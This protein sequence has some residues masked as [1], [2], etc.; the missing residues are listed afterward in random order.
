[1]TEQ[2]TQ[3]P[4]SDNPQQNT[5]PGKLVGVRGVAA[6]RGLGWF[7]EGFN[8]FKQAPWIWILNGLLFFIILGLL[9]W[10]PKVPVFTI[11]L[12]PAFVG[13]LML[14][15]RDL[16]LGQRLRVAHLFAGFQNRAGALIGLG[17]LNLIL[18]ILIVGVVFGVMFVL[19]SVDLEI[20]EAWESG[21]MNEQQMLFILLVMLFMLPLFM[22]FWFAPTLIVLHDDV[23]ILE[24]MRLSFLGCLK[25]MLPFL[26]YG[27]VGFILMLLANILLGLGLLVASFLFNAIHVYGNVMLIPGI[28]AFILF[29]L[30]W[31]VFVSVLFGSI[32]ASYK[33]IFLD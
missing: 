20:L 2:D 19:G 13:G 15:C 5:T 9:N 30:G 27:I 3:P 29:S 32:Y 22:L 33:E 8:L 24:A 4:A 6:S 18:T 31:F 28:L 17:A 16:D 23:G 21:Q 7:A 26:I 10:I 14:G 12:T 25:N 11:L 1:M